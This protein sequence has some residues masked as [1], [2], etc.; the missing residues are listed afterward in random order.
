MN[1]DVTDRNSASSVAKIPSSRLSR[2][3]KMGSLASRV[4]GN[5]LF[6]GAKQLSKGQSPQ[7][8]QLVLT[9]KN[10]T[11]VAEK[12]AQLR[13]AAMK[14]GQM[15]SMDSGD[16]L[17][18][19]ISD[20]LAKLRDDA[21]AMP[22][23][24][25]VA[26]LKQQWGQ[27]WLAPFAQFE[28]RP[29]AAASIG[30]VHLAYLDS[31]EKLAVKI[32]YPG[33]KDS[34]DSDI[35]NVASLLKMAQLVPDHVQFDKLLTEAKAQLHHEADYH[36]E[37]NLLQ[38]YY[39]WV[40]DTPHFVVPR[41]YSQLSTDSILV[42]QFIEGVPIESVL[43]MAQSI[44]DKVATRLLSLFLDELFTFKLVQTD[45]NFANFM[46]QADP[47]KI[48]LLDFGATRS[49]SDDLSSGYNMLMQG[50]MTSDSALMTQAAAQIGFFQKHITPE[51]QQVIVD[52]FHQACEPLRCEGEYDFANSNLAKRITDSAKAMSTKQDEWHTP[53]TD[54]IFIHRKLAGIYLL[55]SRIK[56]KIDVRQ[57]FLSHQ[58]NI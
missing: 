22:H 18:P 48:V 37:A 32:Q 49:I 34:I 54:A 1:R 50:A 30:Q 46:Y 55:A 35:D 36:Y 31:G 16:L 11:Q 21:K 51:Q 47:D 24:Q 33:I 43:N 57:L 29:F 2:L 19:E 17:P 12:L 13:G 23:K 26:I 40:A 6:E 15:I 41:V 52:I 53:P 39:T 8:Q 3:G 20:I 14:V 9:P 27:D 45:P 4:A 25:L 56:A 42:M 10:M 28:L 5:V 38:Q 44:R 7:L 58:N